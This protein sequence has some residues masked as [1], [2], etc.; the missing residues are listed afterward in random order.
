MAEDAPPGK[1]NPAPYLLALSRLGVESQ[2]A[3]AF[4]DSPSGIRA[5]VNAGIFT[6]GVTS[7][8]SAESLIA[9]GAT[10]AISAKPR[11]CAIADFSAPHLWQ[12]LNQN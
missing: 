12:F 11:R 1:P 8:H 6:I 9:A 3:I 4:E 7:T 2:A 5:A 10:M